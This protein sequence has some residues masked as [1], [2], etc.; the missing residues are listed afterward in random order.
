MEIYSSETGN[1]RVTDI[2]FVRFGRFCRLDNGVYWNGAIHWIT[3]DDYRFQCYD[4]DVEAE[5][6]SVIDMPPKG[7]DCGLECI[8]YFGECNGHLHLV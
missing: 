8:R 6:I 1:W 2:C 4:F 7:P 5:K 3:N